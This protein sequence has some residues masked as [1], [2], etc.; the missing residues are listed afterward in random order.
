MRKRMVEF[1]RKFEN[2]GIKI[3]RVNSILIAKSLNLQL[4]TLILYGVWGPLW[5]KAIFS[6]QSNYRVVYDRGISKG[7]GSVK[8]LRHDVYCVSLS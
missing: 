7:I 6:A 8:D 3:T 1:F 5:S 2:R 4:F